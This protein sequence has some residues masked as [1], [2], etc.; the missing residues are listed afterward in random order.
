[1]GQSRGLLCIESGLLEP[2][3][4]AEHGVHGGAD[5]VAHGGQEAPLG[6]HGL[7]GLLVGKLQ[8]VLLLHPGR[9]ILHHPVDP[10]P[11]PL[12][13]PPAGKLQPA[14]SLGGVLI[15]Q[16]MGERSPGLQHGQHGG[17]HLAPVLVGDA[18]QGLVGIDPDLLA[19]QPQ[20]FVTAPAHKLHPGDGSPQQGE[21]QHHTGHR[22]G[23]GAQA[24]LCL[25]QQAGTLAQGADVGEGD[26]IPCRCLGA[27]SQ[28][29]LGIGVDLL[30]Q[31]QLPFGALQ[32]WRGQHQ[33]GGVARLHAL[34]PL[35]ALDHLPFVIAQEHG[36]G[37]RLE[38]RLPELAFQRQRLLYLVTLAGLLGQLLAGTPD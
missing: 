33:I 26:K 15:A 14:G 38:E 10:P 29:D 7:L 11:L 19:R 18:S 31:R 17:S 21:L 34:G 13:A 24:P 1:M 23:E 30:V 28:G 9:H 16:Q 6:K 37:E 4:Q 35:V 25:T 5:L 20:Q 3:Q 22:I 32:L 2:L 8:G 36:H 27:Q 12:T